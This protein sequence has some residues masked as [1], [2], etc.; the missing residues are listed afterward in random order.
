MRSIETRPGPRDRALAVFLA[1]SLF[2]INALPTFLM[3]FATILPITH[4]L[5]LMRYGLL[6][7]SSELHDIW[8]LSNATTM[9]SLSLVVVAMFAAALSAISVRVFARAALH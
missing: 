5:A 9:A 3:W 6:S 4:A 7:D 8:R 2:P 1:G